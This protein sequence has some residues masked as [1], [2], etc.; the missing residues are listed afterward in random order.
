[1]TE[2]FKLLTISQYTAALR[3]LEQSIDACDDD[4]WAAEHIDGTVSQVVFHTLFYSDL[5]LERE[6]KG[7][8]EQAFH[9]ENQGFFQDYEEAENRPP[10]NFYER[11]KCRDYLGHC[12]RKARDVMQTES[13]ESLGGAS[14]FHWRNTT[15]AENHIYNIRHIQHHAA[16]L[17]LRNQLRGGAPLKWIGQG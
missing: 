14:G 10:V 16:Q 6:E 15:R 4:T 8:K 17:G 7:F 2:L 11:S 12:F 5:Y 1:M 3:T 13:E 9:R